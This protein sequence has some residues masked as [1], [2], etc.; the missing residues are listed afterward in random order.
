MAAIR[1]IETR[2]K[3]SAVDATG[4]TFAAVAA[5]LRNI[6]NTADGVSKRLDHV[7][8]RMSAVGQSRFRHQ[9]IAARMGAVAPVIAGPGFDQRAS[10]VAGA[11]FKAAMATAAA[12]RPAPLLPLPSCRRSS[13]PA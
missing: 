4:G 8:A 9:D 11:G 7:S 2:A 1:T 13:T 5:K 3:I 6:D 10:Q 12:A